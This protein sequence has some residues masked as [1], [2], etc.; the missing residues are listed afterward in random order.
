MSSRR[1]HF[2]YP[3]HAHE[4]T[5]SCY[6]NRNFLLMEQL[7]LFLA[8]AINLAR[9]KHDIKVLAYVF[10]PNHV[11]LLIFPVRRDYLISMILL[12]IKQ[13]ASR[14]AL[15]Q[16][17]KYNH[18]LLNQF[19]TG[20]MS[21]RYRIWQE[22]GGYDRNINNPDTLLKAVDYIH[23]NPVRKGLVDSPDKWRWSSFGDWHQDCQGP[24]KIEKENLLV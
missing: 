10:M 23:N 7:C 16:A 21:K 8:D 13:S 3:G 11:H 6:R 12:T 14:R 9:E 2:N 20:I 19:K 18:E 5:F 17:R 1:V 22:G 15:I 4:L 24:I